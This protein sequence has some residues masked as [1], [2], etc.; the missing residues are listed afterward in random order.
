MIQISLKCVPKSY[1]LP[2]VIVCSGNGVSPVW[3]QAFMTATLVLWTAQKRSKW[4]FYVN[5]N[6]PYKKTLKLIDKIARIWISTHVLDNFKSPKWRDIKIDTRISRWFPII[7][8]KMSFAYGHQ[9]WPKRC[10]HRED[11][12][13]PNTDRPR[14]STE[15]ILHIW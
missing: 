7:R 15:E 8:I 9:S 6:R 10:H 5:Q 2:Y 1:M 3:R 11:I 13:T 14:T 4:C 12:R